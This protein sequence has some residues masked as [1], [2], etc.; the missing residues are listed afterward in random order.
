MLTD[1]DMSN[2]REFMQVIQQEGREGNKPNVE[3]QFDEWLYNDNNNS[4]Y[5]DVQVDSVYGTWVVEEEEGEKDH[6]ELVTIIISV[7]FN[8]IIRNLFLP[9]GNFTPSKKNMPRYLFSRKNICIM[10]EFFSLFLPV[11]SSLLKAYMYWEMTSKMLKCQ[12]PLLGV[13]SYF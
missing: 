11:F 5:N 12:K 1:K 9:S 8:Y 7:L 10:R 13:V 3:E 2:P 6:Y 4:S